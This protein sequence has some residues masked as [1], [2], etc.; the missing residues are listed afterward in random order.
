[1]DS[2]KWRAGAI[3]WI[4]C[5]EDSP[6]WIL[7]CRSYSNTL[8]RDAFTAETLELKETFLTGALVI[9]TRILLTKA[10]IGY[11]F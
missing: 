7:R 9:F 5:N 4:V 8:N 11:T 3:H 6:V 1:M 10:K 2:L